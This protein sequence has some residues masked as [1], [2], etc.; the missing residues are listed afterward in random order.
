[1]RLKM[2][3]DGMQDYEYL[4]ALTN[5]GEGSFAAQQAH[6]FITN[7]YTFDNNPAALENARATMGTRI[8]QLALAKL[9]GARGQKAR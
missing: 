9:G 7:S 3:R 4:Y 1:M 6:T 5:A 8:H 2:I